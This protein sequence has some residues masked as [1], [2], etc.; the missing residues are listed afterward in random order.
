MRDA[1]HELRHASRLWLVV[2]LALEIASYAIA[3]WL[4]ILLR[5]EN[6]SLGW[7]TT[8]RVA[9]VMWGLGSLPPVA[10]ADGTYAS[11]RA[12]PVGSA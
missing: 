2:A 12:Q 9:L 8:A 11:L 4:L 3:G 7:P 6:D 1:I 5:G 10:P